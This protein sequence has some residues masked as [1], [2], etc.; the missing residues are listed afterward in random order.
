MKSIKNVKDL[1]GQKFGRLTVIGLQPTESRKTFWIC[2]CDCGNMK[3][4][5]SDSLQCGAI[6]SCG[7]LKK[8]QDKKNL[9]HSIDGGKG[10]LQTKSGKQRFLHG[11]SH[12]RLHDIWLGMKGR[13]YNE[14][15]ERYDR[16]GGRGIVVCN[17][18]L[19]NFLAFYEWSMSHG[20]SDDLTIDRI[21]VDGN[22]CPENCRWATAKEQSNNRSTNINIKIGNATKTLMQW[23][24]I[25]EVDYKKIHARYERHG[26]NGIDELFN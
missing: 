15:N 6:R 23:C 13:C 19:T 16:Y 10:K 14:H 4:V 24:E 18:W 5:R 1:T 17:E 9:I 2:L 26:F 25:F 11:F 21:D 22:Y 20:Y 8:E 7:C 3:I 12:T